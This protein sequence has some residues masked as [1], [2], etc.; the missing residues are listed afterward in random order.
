MVMSDADLEQII[1]EPEPCVL[2]IEGYVN[3]VDKEPLYTFTKKEMGIAVSLAEVLL[4][5]KEV[6][7][8]LIVD[9]ATDVVIREF[10]KLKK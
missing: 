1:P 4:E 2:I 9:Q 7:H 10:G 6:T 3:V 5:G 8:V